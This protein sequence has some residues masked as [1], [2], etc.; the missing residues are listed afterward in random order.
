MN[1]KEYLD[2][3]GFMKIVFLIIIA[4]I[5]LAYFNVDV[6]GIINNI[7]GNAGVQKVFSLIGGAVYY[8]IIPLGGY[9]WDGIKSIF[10]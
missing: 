3:L 5:A 2:K 1:N 10:P 9:L 6:R 7:L 4:V 8:Y